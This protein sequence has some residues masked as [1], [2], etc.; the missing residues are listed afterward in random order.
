MQRLLFS[1][2]HKL[3]EYSYTKLSIA[4]VNTIFGAMDAHMVAMD[5]VVLALNVLHWQGWLQ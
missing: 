4:R 5:W 3:Q 1:C 2:Q